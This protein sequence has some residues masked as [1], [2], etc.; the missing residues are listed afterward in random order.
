MPAPA[1]EKALPS[2][3]DYL[4][5][6]ALSGNACALEALEQIARMDVLFEWE[7]RQLERLQPKVSPRGKVG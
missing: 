1:T 7:A 4:R 3:R 5:V 2:A 6:Q